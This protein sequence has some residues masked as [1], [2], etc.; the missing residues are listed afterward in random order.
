M[1]QWLGRKGKKRH[2][3]SIEKMDDE[4]APVVLY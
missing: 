4:T 3:G 1:L 2:E